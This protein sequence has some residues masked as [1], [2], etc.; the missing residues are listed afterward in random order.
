MGE[1]GPLQD[2]LSG[3]D[4]IVNA[5]SAMSHNSSVFCPT[6]QDACLSLHRYM[7]IW[8][9]CVVLSYKFV[10][11]VFHVLKKYSFNFALFPLMVYTRDLVS[12]RM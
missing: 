7:V 6:F 10:S 11:C 8:V 3:G 9:D 1:I 5:E 2:P 12:Y 4:C